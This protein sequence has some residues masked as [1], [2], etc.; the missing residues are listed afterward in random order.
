[1]RRKLAG[2]AAA[3]LILSA[4]S[5]NKAQTQQLPAGNA[6]S[7]QTEQSAAEQNMDSAVTL[8]STEEQ[9][10]VVTG[11]PET[12]TFMDEPYEYQADIEEVVSLSFTLPKFTLTSGEAS[13]QINARFEKWPE[14][15]KDFA[16][17][18]VYQTAQERHAIGFLE[19]S[20]IAT[21]EDGILK[22]TYT[23]VERYSD[24]DA[25]IW[26]EDTFCFDAATG[27]RADA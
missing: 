5:A 15:W 9:K 7:E 16:A 19:G 4:C 8:P 20:Y 11:E 12:D 6:S 13:D 27:E 3:F 26:H 22:V 1:M 25:E 10:P 24:D 18:T 14:S 17:S 23:V 21:L 2:I